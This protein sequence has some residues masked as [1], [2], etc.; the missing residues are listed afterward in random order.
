MCEFFNHIPTHV[1]N[2]SPTTCVCFWLFILQYI[3]HIIFVYDVANTLCL[4]KEKGVI[5]RQGTGTNKAAFGR[6]HVDM[7]VDVVC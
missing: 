3:A 1:C 5:T 7:I 2:F 6:A 4:S